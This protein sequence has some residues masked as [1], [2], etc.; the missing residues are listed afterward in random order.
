MSHVSP[1][2]FQ[3]LDQRVSVEFSSN[4]KRLTCVGLQTKAHGR[5]EWRVVFRENVATSMTRNTSFGLFFLNLFTVDVLRCFCP[6][7]LVWT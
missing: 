1:A 3:A 5:G 7:S 6:S 2:N 4:R